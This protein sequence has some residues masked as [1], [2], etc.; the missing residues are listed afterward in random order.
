MVHTEGTA[1]EFIHPLQF[2]LLISQF[3][4]VQEQLSELTERGPL[5]PEGSFSLEEALGIVFI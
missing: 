1:S 4:A 5:L 3:A 2:N